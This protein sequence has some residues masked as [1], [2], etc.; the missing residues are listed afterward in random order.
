MSSP[1]PTSAL[2]SLPGGGH[3]HPLRPTSPV[4]HRASV[5]DP[6]LEARRNLRPTGRLGG[7][8]MPPSTPP[9]PRPAL[10]PVK[11]NSTPIALKATN[12]PLP[13]GPPPSTTTTS[14]PITTTTATT[15][16]ANATSA[17]PPALPLSPPP[18]AGTLLPQPVPRDMKR[19]PQ[20]SIVLSG[21][22]LPPSTPPPAPPS[23]IANVLAPTS[24]PA[25]PSPPTDPVPALQ[26]QP[27]TQVSQPIA[28]VASDQDSRPESVDQANVAIASVESAITEPVIEAALTNDQTE[29]ESRTEEAE[30][31]AE[32]EAAAE[33]QETTDSIAIANA[34]AS[35]DNGASL[36]VVN[37]EALIISEE[38]LDVHITDTDSEEDAHSV[39][40]RDGPAFVTAAIEVVDQTMGKAQAQDTLAS[41]NPDISESHNSSHPHKDNK[42]VNTNERKEQ[43]QNE[44]EDKD[45]DED[46]DEDKGIESD[47]DF[48]DAEE[49]VYK[50][51]EDEIKAREVKREQSE[52]ASR[53]IGQKMLQGWAMLQDPCPNPECHGVPLLRSREKKEYCVVCEN[54]F[55][56]EQ[57]LEHG[58]FTIVPAPSSKVPSATASV[59]PPPPQEAAAPATSVAS[60]STPPP[61]TTA[62]STALEATAAPSTPAP[63][64]TVLISD[65]IMQSGLVS[66]LF[67]AVPLTQPPTTA[68]PPPPP[69][70]VQAPASVPPPT[71]AQAQSPASLVSPNIRASIVPSPFTSP[72]MGRNQRELHGRVSSSIILPPSQQIL[73]KHLSEDFDKLASED[74]DARRH[75]NIIRK[76]GEFSNKSLPP[77]PPAP[78]GPAPPAPP[79]GHVPLPPGSRPTSTYS[80]SSGYHPSENER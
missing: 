26:A 21:P 65:E 10:N 77:V 7:S 3:G 58:T 79:A 53:L 11:P 32:T 14:S 24:I 70:P 71:H 43:D 66:S 38:S 6:M 45:E 75:M 30:E 18:Q 15:N 55:Q 52:R 8:P 27:S 78:T 34:S 51:T 64:G 44:H 1:A 48:E 9:P 31:E 5:I 67:P 23:S 40:D 46:E 80:N 63:T 72:S 62:T 35:V 12:I 25:F 54:Y 28:S 4:S 61:T 29:A 57:D 19:S 20:A 76:V 69:A 33:A 16:T 17:T 22:I 13:P 59:P 41:S 2:P 68:V 56:R 42:D 49:E 73:G 36:P 47:D 50:P 39:S 37:N 60:T 74:E